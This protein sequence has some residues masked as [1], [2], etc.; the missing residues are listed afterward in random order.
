MKTN[1][2]TCNDF[3]NRISENGVH[4]ISL[5]NAQD[6]LVDVFERTIFRC[7]NCNRY[8]RLKNGNEQGKNM[9]NESVFAPI[10]LFDCAFSLF[11]NIQEI[12][13]T[14][15][16]KDAELLIEQTADYITQGV[17]EEN[18]EA[19]SK[20][21]RVLIEFVDQLKNIQL[22][23]LIKIAGLL[24]I[25]HPDREMLYSKLSSLLNNY[26]GENNK[27]EPFVSNIRKVYPKKKIANQF[28]SEIQKLNEDFLDEIYKQ[29]ISDENV[30]ISTPPSYKQKLSVLE[31]MKNNAKNLWSFWEEYYHG[32]AI[33]YFYDK[34]KG[35]FK[36]TEADVIAASYHNTYEMTEKEMLETLSRFS[37]NELRNEGFDI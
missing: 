7:R 28:A 10:S 16:Q 30:S 21:I 22:P 18:Y 29:I 17:G 37:E 2:S 8:Y 6:E 33:T 15:M 3:L 12:E 14:I 13:K 24:D 23:L 32:I 11:P 5:L 27:I 4:E 1:C 31:Q 25:T 36:R 9:E 19:I 26:L 34:N 20:A 35:G